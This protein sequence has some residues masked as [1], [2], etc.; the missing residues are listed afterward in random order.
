MSY[1]YETITSTEVEGNVFTLVR[2]AKLDKGNLNEVC[3]HYGLVL[4]PDSL[5]DGCD[6]EEL[7]EDTAIQILG[8]M[9]GIHIYNEKT[10]S[11]RF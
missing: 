9:F 6:V 3:W 5:Q 10:G 7:D 8:N 4:E 11:S 2:G 1:V